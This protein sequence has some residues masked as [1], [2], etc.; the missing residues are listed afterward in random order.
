[1]FS[2]AL[3]LGNKLVFGGIRLFLVVLIL[4]LVQYGIIQCGIGIEKTSSKVCGSQDKQCPVVQCVS[5]WGC[6]VF[7]LVVCS[8]R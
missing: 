5:Y 3:I 6:D 1:M 7:G 4:A 8:L 2:V